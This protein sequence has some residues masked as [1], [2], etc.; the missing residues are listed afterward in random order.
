MLG[1]VETIN[2]P[3]QSSLVVVTEIV[4]WGRGQKEGVE[5]PVVEKQTHRLLELVITRLDE[6]SVESTP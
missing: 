5:N 6:V 2:L 1:C 4:R 3:N